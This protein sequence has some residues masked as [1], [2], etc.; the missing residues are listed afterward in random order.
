MKDFF[1]SH[2][3]NTI[4]TI[5]PFKSQC[6]IFIFPENGRKPLVSLKKSAKNLPTLNFGQLQ[7]Q[8][9]IFFQRGINVTL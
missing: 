5:N 4:D 7:I 1:D 6:S 2:H 8:E 3:K 9:S